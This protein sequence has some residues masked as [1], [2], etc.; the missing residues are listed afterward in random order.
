[1]NYLYQNLSTSLRVAPSR[2]KQKPKTKKETQM[3]K[4][5][6]NLIATEVKVK[7]TGIF[8]TALL[9]VILDEETIFQEDTDLFDNV[10][11]D[12]NVEY[13]IVSDFL[14]NQLELVGETV[15]KPEA[16]GDV[17]VWLR[18]DGGTDVI[19]S[20]GLFDVYQ[21]LHGS[22]VDQVSIR[23]KELEQVIEMLNKET[24]ETYGIERS[25]RYADRGMIFVKDK[26][27]DTDLN[28]NFAFQL[29]KRW[30]S[31]DNGIHLRSQSELYEHLKRV[32]ELFK[33]PSESDAEC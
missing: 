1:M 18:T 8:R 16:D 11:I 26:N 21:N 2:C 20:K 3:Q 22:Y 19:H 30:F 7:L 25:K 24:Q 28:C 13:W 33:L 23:E 31:I 14:A 10:D 29:Q 9:E 4:F 27:T 6:K 5:L 15:F 12:D 17:H 32:V